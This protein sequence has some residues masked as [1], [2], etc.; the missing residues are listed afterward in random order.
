MVPEKS[1][2]FESI[3]QEMQSNFDFPEKTSNTFQLMVHLL[4][5]LISPIPTDVEMGSI[6]S[7]DIRKGSKIHEPT[8]ILNND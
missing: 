3:L 4:K 5:L 8:K 7:W 6:Y 2:M 1:F